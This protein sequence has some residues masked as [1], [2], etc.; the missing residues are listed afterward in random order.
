MRISENDWEK[1]INKL[2]KISEAASE[3]MQLFLLQ[4]GTDDFNKIINHAKVLE[5]KYGTASAELA[6]QMYDEIANASGVHV[7]SA[8]MANEATIAEVARAIN[9]NRTSLN[10]MVRAVSRLV[11]QREADTMLH[12]AKRDRAEF[13]WIPHGDTCPF[14]LVIAS[15]GWQTASEETIKGNHAEHIHANCNC[16]F[17]IRFNNNTEFE[18][19]NPDE[20]REIYDSAEGGSSKEKINYLRRKMYA[21]S[22]E[23]VLK[24]SAN[25][26]QGIKEHDAPKFIKTIDSSDYKQVKKELLGFKDKY[27]NAFTE[28]ALVICPNGDVYHCYGLED[29]VYPNYD[30]GDKI[31]NSTIIHNHPSHRTEYTFSDEDIDL[32]IKY[33]LKELYGVDDKYIYK[34]SSTDLRVDETPDDWRH[35]TMFRHAEV[36]QAAKNNNFGY[37]RIDL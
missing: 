5:G 35:P 7:P 26:E 34:F 10:N 20:L 23:H 4:N 25:E 6:C 3:K 33:K 30:L 8:E 37:R 27:Y 15:K 16:E 13:A 11:K 2:S 29:E 22:K 18:G 32:F 24:I 36:I 9:A 14:C 12:N 1:Y 28:N 31:V 19:Y 17:A 21:R